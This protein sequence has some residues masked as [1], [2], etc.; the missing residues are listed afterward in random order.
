MIHTVCAARTRSGP[1]VGRVRKDITD[2]SP[3][4]VQ[5]LLAFRTGLQRDWDMDRRQPT[6]R[7]ADRTMETIAMSPEIEEIQV[8]AGPGAAGYDAYAR[9]LAVRNR[10]E[11]EV[12][13][14]AA[15]YVDPIESL[16]YF[17][18]QAHTSKRLFVA[19]LGSEIVGQALLECSRDEGDVGWAFGGVLASARRHGVG[20]ALFDHVQRVATA[21]GCATIQ[22]FALH[23]ATAGSGRVTARSGIGS[24]PAGDDGVRFLAKRGYTLEQV[25][26]WNA[27]HLPVDPV[28][29]RSLRD[30]AAVQAGEE[31]RLH[32]WTGPSPDRWLD[33]LA[34]LAAWMERDAPHAGL[35][36]GETAWD[37]GRVRREERQEAQG[38][39]RAL[40]TAVEHVPTGRLAGFTRL[41]L[42]GDPARPVTQG[43]TIVIRE[44]RGRRLGLLLKA[45][46]LVHLDAERPE[47]RLVITGNAEE[48][49]HMLE[50]NARLGFRAVGYTG[51][52]K[53]DLAARDAP[54]SRAAG[55]ELLET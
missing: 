20:T 22:T 36:I 29:L 6:A 30:A 19:R 46:N 9:S 53:L 14:E 37:P 5:V 28:T 52:W 1:R 49:A 39:R 48:N 33:S 15:P 50:I 18:D 40:T 43:V 47:A 4:H 31:Y 44:H 51:A 32:A 26:R 11:A 16:P 35:E 7:V 10:N 42:P 21:D 8:P 17:Q 38:G 55:T 23:A 3:G 12:L 2:T 41:S 13:G 45:A 25:N 54:A 34:A 27:L 24:L